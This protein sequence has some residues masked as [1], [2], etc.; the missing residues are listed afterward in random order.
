MTFV[1]PSLISQMSVTESWFMSV[2]K[3]SKSNMY[4]VWFQELR[5]FWIFTRKSLLEIWNNYWEEIEVF[6]NEINGA[7]KAVQ[8]ALILSYNLNKFLTK[9]EKKNKKKDCVKKWP[10][11]SVVFKD[12]IS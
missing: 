2:S 8:Q 4:H 10:F 5:N 9:I 12:K 1:I 6:Y 11:Y 3:D 7:S